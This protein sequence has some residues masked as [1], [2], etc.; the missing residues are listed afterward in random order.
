MELYFCRLYYKKQRKTKICVE[1]VQILGTIVFIAS[2]VLS[3]NARALKRKKK[4]NVRKKKKNVV[5]LISLTADVTDNVK[6]DAS[7]VKKNA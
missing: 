3:L 1:I 6:R 5:F 4:R 7:R 2:H